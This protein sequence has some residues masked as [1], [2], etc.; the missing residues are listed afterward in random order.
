MGFWAKEF[1]GQTTMEKLHI[2]AENW[3]SGHV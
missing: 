1:R 3:G 2:G